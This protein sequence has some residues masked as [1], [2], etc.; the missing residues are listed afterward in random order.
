MTEKELKELYKLKNIIRYNTRPKQTSE[1]VAEHS[2]YVAV[3]ALELCDEYG[4][5]IEETNKIVIKALLHDMPE[6]EINDIT[7]DA[8]EK[9]KLRP[10]LKKYEDEYFDRR[11]PKYAKLMKNDKSFDQLIVD[12]ADAYS[13]LQYTNHEISLGNQTNEM[14]TIKE[15][16]KPRIEKIQT[17]ILKELEE[18]KDVNENGKIKEK[19][20]K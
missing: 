11:F 6:I 10:Y 15:S 4:L 5:S 19:E 18:R 7:Y 9:L 12:L 8:K 17:E 13:V 20:N 1:S 2:F 3:I 16:I 14:L